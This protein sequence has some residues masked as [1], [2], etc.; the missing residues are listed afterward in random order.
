MKMP[1]PSDEHRKLHRFAGRW[2]G[3]ETLEPSPWGPG[4]PAVGRTSAE[5]ALG[6]MFVVSDYSEE[7]DGQVVFR[8]HG[9]FGWDPRAKQVNWYWFDVMGETPPA[10]ARGAWDGDTLILRSTSPMGEGRYTY[11]FHGNDRYEFR[12]DNSF[13]GG[14]TFVKLMEGNYRRD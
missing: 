13:D 8:G 14:K 4:G 3:E 1:T 12:I 11:R 7:K 5:V 2:T 6:G 9:V 10:P